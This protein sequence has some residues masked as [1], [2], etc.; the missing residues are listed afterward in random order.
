MW[1]WETFLRTLPL[2]PAHTRVSPKWPWNQ[3]TRLLIWPLAP[4]SW[5]A[6]GESLPLSNPKLPQVQKEASATATGAPRQPAVS[7]GQRVLP[8]PGNSICVWFWFW[9]WFP[10]QEMLLSIASRNR[11]CFYFFP[12]EGSMGLSLSQKWASPGLESGS[13]GL[14]Q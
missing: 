2:E 7:A 12:E 6:L 3:E 8:A 13:I 5:V 11:K 4:A 9:F 14:S 10:Q 1:F